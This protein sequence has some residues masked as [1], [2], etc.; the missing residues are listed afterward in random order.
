MEDR[1][2]LIGQRVRHYRTAKQMSLDALAGLLPRQLSA[3]QLANYEVGKSRWPADLVC[4]LAVVFGVDIRLLVGMEY[5]KHEG[6]DNHEWEAEKYKT[7]LLALRPMVRN[8]IYKT[9]DELEQI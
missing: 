6:K 8:V 3:Q 7:K 1:N 5:G 2:K 4:E 9:I